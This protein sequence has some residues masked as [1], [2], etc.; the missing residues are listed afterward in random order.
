MY[1]IYAL[2][3]YDEN[4]KRKGAFEINET[5]IEEFNK[6]G[7]GIYWTLNEYKGRRLAQNITKIKYWIADI[8][9][10][11]KEEQLKRIQS[12]QTTD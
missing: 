7:Y 2:H 10:G 6:L 3:D 5:Q 1:R 11:T 4:L 12:W 9:E 8:D